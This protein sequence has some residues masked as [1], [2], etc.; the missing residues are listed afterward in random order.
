MI[1][2]VNKYKYDFYIEQLNNLKFNNQNS[3]I[4]LIDRLNP[5]TLYKFGVLP[6]YYFYAA[7]FVI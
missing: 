1:A 6:T 4:F 3:S 7:S 5:L 2:F